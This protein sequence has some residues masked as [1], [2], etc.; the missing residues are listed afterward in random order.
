MVLVLV[1]GR[2]IGS[3][4]LKSVEMTALAHLEMGSNNELGKRNANGEGLSFLVS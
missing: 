2:E 1:S 3:E 4:I